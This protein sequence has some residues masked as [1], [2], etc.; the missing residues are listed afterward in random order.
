MPSGTI[1]PQLWLQALDDAGVAVAGALVNF[2]V[3]GTSTRQ[4]AY[5]DAAL[6]VPLANPQATDAA[7]RL[8]I[9]LSP[10]SYKITMTTPAGVAIGPTVDPVTA[11]GSSGAGL[12]GSTLGEV[13]PFGSN[14]SADV[15]AVAYP[16][17]ATYDTLHPGTSVLQF[18]SA[19]LAPG[20]YKLEIDAVMSAAG[21]FS[22][23]LV[24]LT[25]GTPD[26]P[27]A[28]ATATSL[29]GE[30]SQS[31]AITFAGPG[32]TKKYGIKTKV[33]ANDGFLIGARLVRTA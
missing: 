25:D 2:F 27:L 18:D 17:G 31:A 33:S 20:T 7:G 1:A 22:A 8:V 19:S 6:T 3:S 4:P 32:T 12:I 11:T 10:T 16:S 28:T 21:T 23:A 14:S 9:Y 30:T 13:F 26:V 5:A 15:T 24:N 29:T